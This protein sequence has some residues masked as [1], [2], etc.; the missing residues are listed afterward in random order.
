MGEAARK[1]EEAYEQEVSNPPKAPELVFDSIEECYLVGCDTMGQDRVL[2]EG[3]LEDMDF[4][5][6]FF[7]SQW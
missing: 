2:E 4:K 1:A 6:S 5:V 7:R 3:V